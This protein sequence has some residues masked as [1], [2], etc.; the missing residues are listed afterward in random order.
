MT[1]DV[2]GKTCKEAE[3]CEAQR[4]WK[5]FNNETNLVHPMTFL[6]D[7]PLSEEYCFLKK[8]SGWK[9]T[10]KIFLMA[11]NPDQIKSKF[12]WNEETNQL[13]VIGS[14]EASDLRS[15]Q[16][17]LG[18]RNYAST[19]KSQM[20]L[21]KCRLTIDGVT[22]LNEHTQLLPENGK[23]KLLHNQVMC[24]TWK[25]GSAVTMNR[26]VDQMIGDF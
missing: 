23:V 2:D 5:P 18:V 3:V 24:M 22:V 20:L 9:M 21:R 25:V 12:R 11:C 16:Y 13:E 17:C 14:F 8:Y 19:R 4:I 7:P 6:A 10:H 1:L 26:C 15:K